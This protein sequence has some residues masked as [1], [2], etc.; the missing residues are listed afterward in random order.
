MSQKIPHNWEQR[1]QLREKGQFFT[2]EWIAAAMLEYV[3]PNARL[4]FDPATGDGA[5]YQALRHGYRGQ[6]IHFYG[7]DIDENALNAPIYRED[8]CRIERRDFIADPPRETFAAIVANPPYIRHHRLSETMKR[9]VKHLSRRILGFPLDG[10][11]G[12]HVYF[13]LQALNLLEPEGRLAFI[14][15]ADTCEGIFAKP[16]WRWIAANFRVECVMTFAPEAAPFP[17]IDTNAIIFLIKKASPQQTIVWVKTAQP[18]ADALKHFVQSDFSIVD[19]RYAHVMRRDLSEALETGLSRPPSQTNSPYRLADFATAM[20]GIATGA[21]EF[22]SL[23]RQRA[24]ELD[25]PAEFLKPAIGRTRDVDSDRITPETL[26]ALDR[27]GR[28]TLLFAPDQRAI[29]EFPDS[30]QRYLLSGEQAGLPERPLIKTRTPWYKMEQRRIPP[31][32]FAYLGRRHVRFLRNDAHVLPLSCFLCV[33]PRLENPRF[34]E[35]LWEILNHP[36]TIANLNLVGKSYGD[37]AIKVEPRALEALPIPEQ[38]VERQ[39]INIVN[40]QQMSL[41]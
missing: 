4:I 38:L 22:F 6:P 32:L 10:R 12:L 36:D 30:V 33:F 21:N 39:H 16:L 37:G 27:K 31:F 20:R 25:I 29:E 17:N 2:P 9:A 8:G 23:T 40:M 26:D 41:L 24:K 18:D 35:Q 3:L 7:I 14:L 5:F 28:P 1:E 15:P 19:E 34:V 13:L 11:A